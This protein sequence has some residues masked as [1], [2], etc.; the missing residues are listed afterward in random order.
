MNKKVSLYRCDNYS[1]DQILPLVRKM[2][3]DCA[4]PD[5]KGKRVLVKPNILSDQQPEKAVTTHP[6]VLEAVIR[7]LQEEGAA[8][9]VVGD[10]PA[11]HNKNFKPQKCGIYEVCQQTGAE[12]VCFGQAY[13]EMPI[14]KRNVHIADAYRECDLL[15]SLPKLK[16]H[17][18]MIMTCGIKNTFGL[19][20][21]LHKAKQHAIHNNAGTFASFLVDLNEATIPHFILT[22]AIVGME[23]EGPSNGFPKKLGALF[24]SVNPLALD[25]AAARLIGHNPAEIPTNAEAIK[26]GKWLGSYDAVEYVGDNIDELCCA[27]FK[28]VE[29]SGIDRIM[30]RYVI[31]HVPFLRKLQRR[32]KFDSNR[33]I[34]CKACIR[35]CPQGILALNPNKPNRVTIDDDA[36]IRCFCCQEVCMSDAIKIQG[37]FA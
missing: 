15:I 2:Y 28:R 6:A 7:F 24:A 12:W 5:V 30:L 35:I 19:I 33:C 16:T 34:S 13:S 11:M 25:I 36:C 22:D 26:R 31:K 20:P 10:A 27:N 29:R 1:T 14:G 23:G 8:R 37:L 4:A 17:G 18:F 32:P 9:V 3:H 21:N